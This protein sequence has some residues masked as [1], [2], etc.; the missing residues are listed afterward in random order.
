MKQRIVATTF[1]ES[2]LELLELE[3]WRLFR[4]WVVALL[5][6]PDACGNGQLSLL[7]VLS[8]FNI[9]N[10]FVNPFDAVD[11]SLSLSFLLLSLWSI[12][13]P[14]NA[15]CYFS[16]LIIR[17]SVGLLGRGISPSQGRYLHRTTQIHNKRRQT[18]MPWVGFELTI[19]VSECSCLRPCVPCDRHAVG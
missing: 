4:M 7:P 5:R 15:L 16:F 13:H 12:G 8:L 3:H 11:L 1:Y 18:S 9:H 6:L 10:H 14:S 19:P 2:I 17:Q